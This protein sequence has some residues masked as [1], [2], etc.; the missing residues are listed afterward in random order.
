MIILYS[1]LEYNGILL[2]LIIMIKIIMNNR[3]FQNMKNLILLKTDNIM[4]IQN[5]IYNEIHEDFFVFYNYY[6]YL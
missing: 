1:Y 6:L 4:N 3:D 5:F 2:I